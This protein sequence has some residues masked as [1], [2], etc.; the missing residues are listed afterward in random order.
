MSKVISHEKKKKKGLNLDVK[1]RIVLPFNHLFTLFYI[2]DNFEITRF[3]GWESILFL[4]N[5][6]FGFL[7]GIG[8]GILE[9]ERVLNVIF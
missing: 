5:K 4:T 6:S 3:H 7:E 8:G 2:K 1:Y 9:R